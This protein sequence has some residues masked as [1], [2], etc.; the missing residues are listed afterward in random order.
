MSVNNEFE[1]IEY[2]LK[3][4]ADVNAREHYF[5]G[6]SPLMLAVGKNNLDLVKLLVEHGANPNIK[7]IDEV[8]DT[9]GYTPFLLAIQNNNFDM[10]KLLV[11]HGANVNSEADCGDT[12]LSLAVERNNF[13]MVKY[14]V[15]H[16]ANVNRKDK[17][18]ADL[19]DGSDTPL[20]LAVKN[21]LNGK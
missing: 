10:V 5:D 1:M 9:E 14:L 21:F 20:L 18:C 16:G 17:E 7:Y 11:E 15:E 12:P 4:G 8:G 13:E 6:D 2:L 19:G 3:H